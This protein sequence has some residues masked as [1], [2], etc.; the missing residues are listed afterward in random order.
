MADTKKTTTKKT[1]KTLQEQLI[2]ARKDLLDAKK[3]HRAGELVN[4]K[5]LGGY[6]KKVAQIMT[7]INAEKEAK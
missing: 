4:P 6:R 1:E 2:D 7:K 3:S 5:V